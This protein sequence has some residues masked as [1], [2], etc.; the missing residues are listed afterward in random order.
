MRRSGQLQVHGATVRVEVVVDFDTRVVAD[1]VV[2]ECEKFAT[3]S[4]LE[5]ADFHLPAQDVARRE[6]G[7]GSVSL[8]AVRESGQGLLARLLQTASNFRSTVRTARI[9]AAMHCQP[10]GL[11]RNAIR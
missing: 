3:P 10:R 9:A 5:V 11:I 4:A 2:H 8:I 7:R 6:Q 1:D